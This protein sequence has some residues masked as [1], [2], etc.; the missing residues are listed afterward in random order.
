L[1]A[2]VALLSQ[3]GVTA[4]ADVR[5]APYSRFN[6]QF[7]RDVL[8]RDMS[9]HGVKY[10]FLGHELGARPDDPSCYM[11]G[12]IQYARLAQTRSFRSAV[13][14]VLYV[15]RATTASP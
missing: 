1:K 6:L 13:S 5:S 9:L 4:L 8:Q 10:V 11:E 3:H 7:N 15:A 12:R 14:I 2:F